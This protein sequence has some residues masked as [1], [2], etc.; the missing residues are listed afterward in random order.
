MNTYEYVRVCVYGETTHTCEYVWGVCDRENEEV[1]TGRL[2][3]PRT[4]SSMYLDPSLG[5]RRRG[6][7]KPKTIYKIKRPGTKRVDRFP[8]VLLVVESLTG[9][10]IPSVTTIY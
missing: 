2:H 7:D 10:Q 6:I 3:S 1:L 5:S 4:H 9:T 8:T